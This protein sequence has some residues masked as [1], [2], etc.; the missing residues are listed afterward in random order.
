[1]DLRCDPRPIRHRGHPWACVRFRVDLRRRGNHLQHHPRDDFPHGRTSGRG[2]LVI[3]PVDLRASS[4][5]G[6]YPC[7]VPASHVCVS[8]ALP[9]LLRL[10]ASCRTIGAR[11]RN[12]DG[13]HRLYASKGDLVRVNLHGVD[14]VCLNLQGRDGRK[15][16][17]DDRRTSRLCRD[18]CWY[19]MDHFL[20]H[21][22]DRGPCPYPCPCPRLG[23]DLADGEKQICSADRCGPRRPSKSFYGGFGTGNSYRDPLFY[24]RCFRVS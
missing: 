9:D 7:R 3:S 6:L 11:E 13:N 15:G 1:M 23:R 17:I 2:H 10:R 22:H 19:E 8:C 16:G 14:R 4:Y 12:R 5:R 18:V 24:W 20:Y 21:D